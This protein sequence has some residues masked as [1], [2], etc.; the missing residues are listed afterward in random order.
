MDTERRIVRGR[1]ER[2]AAAAVSLAAAVALFPSGRAHALTLAE[3]L[4]ILDRSGRDVAVAL[5]EEQVAAS[6]PVQAAAAWR[7]S[8][9]LYARETLLAEQ[10]GAVFGPNRVPTAEKDFFAYGVRVRQQLYDF[11]RTGATVRAAGFDAESARFETALARNSAALRFILTYVRLL[12]AERL[13]AVQQEEVTRLEAHRDNA[14]ALLEEGAAT[15]NDLLEA[16][17]RLADAVQK[18]L[19]VDNRRALAAARVNSMLLRPLG[20][21]VSP[22]DV[23]AAARDPQSRQEEALAEAER[24]RVELRQL[25]SRAA[26]VDAHRAAVRTEY[27]PHFFATGGY[28]YTQNEYQVHEGNWAVGA[29]MEMNLYAGGLTREKLRQKELE[30]QAVERAR[31]QLL[32]A[33]R[34]EVQDAW[35]ALGTARSRVSATEKAVEQARENL[36]L[37]R[38][39]YSEG[40]GTSTEVLDAVSLLTTAEQNLLDA[41]YDV[42]DAEALLDFS[43]GKDLVTTWG[44]ARAAGEGGRP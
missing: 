28:E 38:L 30:L 41:R 12:R 1:G 14:R 40:V 15:E 22:E 27:Y 35:L 8:A 4:A 31:E 2:I 32:D 6:A 34:L 20:D 44:A 3:G 25:A 33:V 18:R 29:G 11:G 43:V 7:P 39:R 37:E 36:R 24:E 5:A 23:A 42:T 17:V 21:P 26:A 19:Q 13:L 10:P 9:D 16:E